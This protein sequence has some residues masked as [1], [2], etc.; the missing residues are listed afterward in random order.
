MPE[1]RQAAGAPVALGEPLPAEPTISDGSHPIDPSESSIEW[2]GRNL[3]K[4][5]HGRIGLRSG[6]L[7]FAHGELMDGRAVIDLNNIVCFDLHGTEWHDVLTNHL[8]SDDFF[9]VERFPEA[10]V[11]I[12]GARRIEDASLGRPNLEINADVTLKGISAPL[13]FLATSGVT[14]DGKAAPLAVV[15]SGPKQIVQL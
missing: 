14:P 2:S 12:N 11:V 1:A 3:L 13:K 9:E 6:Q 5:H 4:K 7:E 10:L 15:A 8:R